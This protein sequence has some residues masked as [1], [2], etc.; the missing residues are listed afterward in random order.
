MKL[1]CRLSPRTKIITKWI[2][3]LTISPETINYAEENIGTKFMDPGL[4]EDFINLT[5]KG[6]EVK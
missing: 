3:D 1:D 4:R 5:P 2:E 6:R